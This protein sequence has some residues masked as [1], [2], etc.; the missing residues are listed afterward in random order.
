MMP[1]YPIIYAADWEIK[2]VFN[3]AMLCEIENILHEVA[4]TDCYI[5]PPGIIIRHA[6][7]VI[8][9]LFANE[10]VQHWGCYIFRSSQLH[11]LLSRLYNNSYLDRL[12]QLTKKSY[13]PCRF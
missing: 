6:N 7:I 9:L 13:I 8:F 12:Y 4:L 5:H 3:Y 11:S 10:G 1:K 2:F